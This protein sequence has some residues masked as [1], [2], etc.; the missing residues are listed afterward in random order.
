MQVLDVSRSRYCDEVEILRARDP[1]LAKIIGAV[2]PCTLAPRRN[3]FLTLIEAVVWQQLS[4]KAACAIYAKLLDTLGTRRPSPLEIAGAPPGVLAG[5][6]L[7]RQKVRYVKAAARFFANG[8]FPARAVRRYTDDEVVGLLT[9]IDGVGRWTA[10]MFLI[11]GLNRLDV[12]PAG[13]LGLKKA[14]GRHY[15]LDWMNAPDRLVSI[16]DNWRPYRTIG[17][18]YMWSS[19]DSVPLAEPPPARPPRKGMTTMPPDGR[20]DKG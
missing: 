18:W 6:G 3:H 2:G 9:Q 11:F 8:R 4:W 20:A 10:E 19:A 15:H 7:S 16:T 17:T 13:D 12:F 14:I 1:V 5:A